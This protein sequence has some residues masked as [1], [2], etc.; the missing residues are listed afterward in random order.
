ME[1]IASVEIATRHW[2]GELGA[3]VVVV[4]N[5]CTNNADLEWL[6]PAHHDMKGQLDGMTW[7]FDRRTIINP[8]SLILLYCSLSRL[9]RELTCADGAGTTTKI[10]PTEHAWHVQQFTESSSKLSAK[11]RWRHSHCIGQLQWIWSAATVCHMGGFT[12]PR[13]WVE[14]YSSHCMKWDHVLQRLDLGFGLEDPL[15]YGQIDEWA[16]SYD[17][18]YVTGWFVGLW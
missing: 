2:I 6:V 11:L 17:R 10:V 3:V 13:N 16:F 7:L 4:V 18:W 15:P 9:N 8:D 5:Y 1:D 12:T 14:E